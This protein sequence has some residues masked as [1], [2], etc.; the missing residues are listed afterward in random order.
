M[1]ASQSTLLDALRVL[2]AQMVLIGH[3]YSIVLVPTGTLGIGD[4]GVVIFF[5]LSGF[6]IVLTTLQRRSRPGYGLKVYLIDRF[7]RV[8]VPYLPALLCIVAMDTVVAIRAGENPYADYYEIKHFLG[9][10]LMLQQHP[11]GLFLDEILGLSALKIATFGSARPLWTVAVEWWL[12]VCF[13]LVLFRCGQPTRRTWALLVLVLPVPL[14]NMVAGTGQGLSLLWCLSGGLAWL[15]F[16][17]RTDSPLSITDALK[18]VLRGVLGLVLLLCAARLA[19]TGWLEH[20][21]SF[22]RLIVYDF[23]LYALIIVACAIAFLLLEDRVD[24]SRNRITR[25]AAD[26]SY[27]LY[28]L[29]Y[30]FIV[31]MHACGFLSGLPIVDFVICFVACDALAVVFWFLFERHYRRVAGLLSGRRDAAGSLVGRAATDAD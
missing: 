15:Y 30:S 22:E 16:R 11:L 2:A 14:F 24:S 26:Y 21:T 23:N 4:L 28:L 29:H 3:I 27:S 8:F 20:R 6:L 31:L 12:Y 10:L 5:V 18:P 1:N 17:F 13:G 9:S 25:F 19:W 7:C